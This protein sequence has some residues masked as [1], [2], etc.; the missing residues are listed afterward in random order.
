MITEDNV[1]NATSVIERMKDMKNNKYLFKKILDSNGVSLVNKE[2]LNMPQQ[3]VGMLENNSL[4]S[5]GTY[6]DNRSEVNSMNTDKS[7]DNNIKTPLGQNAQHFTENLLR[8]S[9]TQLKL[10]ECTS[11]K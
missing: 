3:Q 6:Q 9:N 1:E 11:K 7:R 5:P 2:V 4:V 10:S 8:G